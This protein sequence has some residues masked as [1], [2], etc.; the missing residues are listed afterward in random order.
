MNNKIKNFFGFK[1]LPFS[2]PIAPQELFQSKSLKEV[3]TLMELALENEDFALIT[4]TAGSGKSSAL[5]YFSSEIDPSVY[6]Q[7]YITAEN[8]KIG[9]IAKLFLAGLNLTVP[10]HGY[11]ALRTLKNEV[12][13][14]YTHHRRKPILIIDEAQQLSITTL[15]SIKNL[16][17]FNMDSESMLLVVLC[18]HFDLVSKIKNIQ[19]ESLRRRIRIHFK[20]EA[21][22]LEECTQY[23]KYHMKR[24]GVD[25]AVFSDEVI[26][27][28]FQ[29]SHG[30][31]SNINNIC[32]DL[33]VHA[34]RQ[35]KEIIDISL[36]DKIILPA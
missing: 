30:T 10:Y 3:Y 23:I 8:Y 35:S 16:V 2:K 1:R 20:V 9:D 21:M 28:I 29:I 26:A 19:L 31:M 25:R 12:V 17:N 27:E 6:P 5:R 4:G 7:V 36:L 15:S 22:S 14:M 33:I 11:T 34:T 32:F 24:A 13:K 18:G